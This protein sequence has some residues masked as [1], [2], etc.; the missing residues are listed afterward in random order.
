MFVHLEQELIDFYAT[1]V[2]VD[3]R[4]LISRLWLLERIMKI[5]RNI[6]SVITMVTTLIVAIQ[7][8]KAALDSF[9]KND[10]ENNQ[11]VQV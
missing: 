10:M 7:Q 6:I 1:A 9:K 3:S 5:V 4:R 2:G 8:L 11:N